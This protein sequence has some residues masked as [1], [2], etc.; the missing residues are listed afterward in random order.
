MAL[1]LTKDV[2]VSLTKSNPSLRTVRIELGWEK[3]VKSVDVD[4]S[5]FGLNDQGRGMESHLVFFNQTASSDGAVKHSGDNRTGEGDGPDESITANLAAI[6][7]EVKELSV[8]MTI[9]RAAERGHSM[10]SLRDCWAKLVNVDTGEV[11]REYDLDAQFGTSISVQVGSLVRV[12][13]EWEFK[14]V[15]VGYPDKTFEDIAHA[16]GF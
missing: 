10:G 13:A 6:S 7:P 2:K 5:V 12:G 4:V 3:L 14:E 11:I 15:G 1:K 16:Y 9:D 8:F